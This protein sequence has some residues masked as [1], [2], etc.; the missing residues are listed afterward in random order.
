MAAV[1]AEAR[2][3]GIEWLHV[4]ASI[5]AREFFESHGFAV[6]ARQTVK[7]RGVEMENFRMVRAAI[8]SS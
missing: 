8:E 4:E 2:R 7:S 1:I 5:T 6:L 3:L